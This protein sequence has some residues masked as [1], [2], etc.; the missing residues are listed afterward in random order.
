LLG[1]ATQVSAKLGRCR[2]QVLGSVLWFL[3][4]RPGRR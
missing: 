2:V 4:W 3:P 1:A